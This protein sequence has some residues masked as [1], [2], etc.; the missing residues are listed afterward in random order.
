MKGIKIQNPNLMVNSGVHSS[1]YDLKDYADFIGVN[2]DG[3]DS[4]V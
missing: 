2:V 1:K 4:R 3:L